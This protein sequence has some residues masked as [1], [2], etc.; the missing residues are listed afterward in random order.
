MKQGW[1]LLLVIMGCVL[2]FGVGSVAQLGRFDNPIKWSTYM[3]GENC[4]LDKAATHI[5][6]NEADWQALWPKLS[7]QP[8]QTAPKDVDWNKDQLIVIAL[9]TK[10]TPGYSVYVETVERTRPSEYVI[11]Y[12]ETRPLQGQLLPQ[13]TT[14]PFVII[15][16]EKTVGTPQVEGR[17]ITQRV[18]S[19]PKTICGCRCGCSTC[20]CG[21]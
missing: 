16:V 18:F 19:A 21:K 8:A 15:R 13:V 2:S 1:I 3:Q 12:V 17:N 11:R 4:G 6:R 5:A 10:G 20:R 7:G 14:A 9:G